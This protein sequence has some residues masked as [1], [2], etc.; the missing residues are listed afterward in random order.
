MSRKKI[1]VKKL[2]QDLVQCWKDA[3]EIINKIGV[4]YSVG[5]PVK[6]N[7][8]NQ[9]RHGELTTAYNSEEEKWCIC[10]KDGSNYLRLCSPDDTT[11]QERIDCSVYL[12]ELITKVQEAR[13]QDVDAIVTAIDNMNLNMKPFLE[14]LENSEKNSLENR[15]GS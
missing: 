4:P 2:S 12:E 14:L 7:K 5:V 8:G 6:I 10:L 3:E 13:K 15:K 1:D 11:N 9:M